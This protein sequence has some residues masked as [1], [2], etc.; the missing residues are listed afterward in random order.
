M[1]DGLMATAALCNSGFAATGR[2]KFA[3]AFGYPAEK[4][5]GCCCCCCWNFTFLATI[6]SD[7]SFFL[8]F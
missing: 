8:L 1:S 6:P 4:V 3:A 7:T 5:S 2:A